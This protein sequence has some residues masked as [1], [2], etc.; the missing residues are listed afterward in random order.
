MRKFNKAA[1]LLLMCASVALGACSATNKAGDKI[2]SACEN[3]T[4]DTTQGY[5]DQF[6][7]Y[8]ANKGRKWR[9]DGLT[10]L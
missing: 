6:N 2:D 9:I 3:G 5:V 10:C 7:D 1:G 4:L 8:L